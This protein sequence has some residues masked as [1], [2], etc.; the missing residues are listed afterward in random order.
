MHKTRSEASSCS[1]V[2]SLAPIIDV[3]VVETDTS[4]LTSKVPDTGLRNSPVC[5][6]YNTS[7][8]LGPSSFSIFSYFQPRLFWLR[9]RGI[10]GF[11]KIPLVP[12]LLFL[13]ILSSLIG[14]LGLWSRSGGLRSLK[15]LSAVY[16]LL[17]L[18]FVRN[19]VSRSTSLKD[20]YI[21]LLHIKTRL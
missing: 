3:E 8:P 18:N 10:F 11:L 14:R 5:C 6:N 4:F 2:S 7:S 16:R 20:L 1:K 21:S 13:F 9:R 17:G 19:G 12:I 15:V